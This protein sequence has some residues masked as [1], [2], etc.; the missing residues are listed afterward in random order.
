MQ[1]LKLKIQKYFLIII[2]FLFTVPVFAADIYFETNTSKVKLNEQ[3]EVKLLVDSDGENINAFEGQVL[4]ADDIL[5]LKEIRIGN[6]IVNFWILEP[7]IED[8]MV[9]FSGI[10]PGGFGR[11]KGLI[12]SLIFESKEEGVALFEINNMRVLKNDGIGSMA[13]LSFRPF[14]IIV[15]KEILNEIPVFSKIKDIEKPELFQPEIARDQNLFEGKYFIVFATV[16]KNSGIDHY[17]IKESRQKILSF[18]NKWKQKESPQ[19][20]KDQELRSFIWIK[21]IDRAGNERIVKVNPQD[22]FL[23][24]ENYENWIIIMIG[25]LILIFIIRNLWKRKNI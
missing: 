12:F 6:S 9:S 23:W 8:N 2:L 4:F 24:Y 18:F 15:S 11:E 20:L 21:A 14:E 16:D 10:T 17:Q 22:P 1:K 7:K 19:V 3:F 25:L 5:D 13:N